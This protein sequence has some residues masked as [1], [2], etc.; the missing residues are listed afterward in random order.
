MNHESEVSDGSSVPTPT[1]G[2]DAKR[3]TSGAENQIYQNS[4][5]DLGIMFKNLS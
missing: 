1:H 4:V 3:S 2:G 5:A